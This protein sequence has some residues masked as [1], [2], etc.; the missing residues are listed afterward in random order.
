MAH[1]HEATLRLG[2]GS[3]DITPSEPVLLAGQFHA[4]V[5]EGVRDPISV[6]A[7]A[8]DSGNDHA[9]LV[10]CDL[11]S[12]PESMLA[13]VSALVAQRAPDLDATKLVI[14]ATHTHAAP[15][16]RAD[17]FGGASG[18]DVGVALPVMSVTAYN[19]FAAERIATAVVTAWHGRAAGRVAFG[20]GQAV[21]GRNR[22]MAYADGHSVMY[23]PT[24]VA[25]FSHVEGYEDHSLNLLATYD[26]GG[27]L[28]GLLI[29]VPCPSQLSEAEYTISADFW[30]DARLELRAKYGENLHLLPQCSAAGDLSPRPPFERSAY[31]RMERLA[32]R[33]ARQEL[34]HRITVAV[35]ETLAVIG[36][37]AGVPAPMQH[38]VANLTVAANALTAA[39]VEHALREAAG[40]MQEYEK[41]KA[42]LAAEPSLRDK[43]RWYQ[44]LTMH[45]RRAK[46]YQGVADRFARQQQDPTV[47]VS[48]HVIRLG[49]MA[50]VSNPFEYYLDLGVIIKARSPAVQTFIVQL[51]GAGTYA[52]SER[53]IQGG[54]YGAVPSSNRIDPI[55]SRQLAEASLALL[56]ELWAPR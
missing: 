26:A 19:A 37:H 2:W 52:P 1:D 53:S 41:E 50:I 40:H 12:V 23:G 55:G 16:A 8:L 22:R 48:I 28:T 20:L 4:R 39:D 43:P 36:P 17:E 51:A 47:A 54:G 32:G 29:N 13:A 24:N 49:D 38:R 6:T 44:K 45:F 18:A 21:V 14:S 25:E 33:N 15:L 46:W 35:A 11:V 34:A 5:S 27:T 42:R 30:H 7:L 56:G 31:S 3:A 10:S 9:V